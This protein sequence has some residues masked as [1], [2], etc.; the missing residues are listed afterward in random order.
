MSLMNIR[1]VYFAVAAIII[2]GLIVFAV[3]ASRGGGAHDMPGM[4]MGLA[5]RVTSAR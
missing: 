1:V 3:L 2:A 4:D 5:V